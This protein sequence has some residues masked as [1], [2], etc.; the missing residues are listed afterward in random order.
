MCSLGAVYI[1]KNTL[2]VYIVYLFTKTCHLKLS[3]IRE[4]LSAVRSMHVQD[5]YDNPLDDF[6]MLDLVLDVLQLIVILFAQNN[7]TP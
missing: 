2:L 3:S 7:Q 6:I 4:Y 5:C 1:K